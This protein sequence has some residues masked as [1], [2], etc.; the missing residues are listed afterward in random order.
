MPVPN[1]ALQ[2]FEMGKLA[3]KL[4]TPAPAP[5]AAPR[6]PPPP[7]PIS[8]NTAV[9]ERSYDDMSADEYARATGRETPSTMAEFR[10]LQRA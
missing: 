3:E 5:V 8:G 10:R 7:K 1:M 4:A 9:A 6:V 2:I